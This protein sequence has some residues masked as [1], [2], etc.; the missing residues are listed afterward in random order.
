MVQKDAQI[1]AADQNHIFPTQKKKR[2]NLP[3][4]V[5]VNGYCDR[6]YP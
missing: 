2:P 6:K 3:G 4:A 5:V 1:I